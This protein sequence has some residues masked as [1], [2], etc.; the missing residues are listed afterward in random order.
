MKIEESRLKQLIITIA[1]AFFWK[2][3]NMKDIKSTTEGIID[4]VG[5]ILL[6]NNEHLRMT[7]V[8]AV[9]LTSDHEMDIADKVIEIAHTNND[10]DSCEGCGLLSICHPDHKAEINIDDELRKAAINIIQHIQN[11]REE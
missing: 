11:L 3:K 2:A 9:V 8:E 7:F 10:T 1:L 5:E 6:N 4:V